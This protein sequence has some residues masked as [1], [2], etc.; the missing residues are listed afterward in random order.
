MPLDEDMRKLQFLV[1]QAKDKKAHQPESN[2]GTQKYVTDLL[3]QQL[4]Q[5]GFNTQMT[6]DHELEVSVSDNPISIGVNCNKPDAEG[7]FV[8]EISAHADEEQDWF[9]KIETQ[10]MIKQLAQ[11]VEQTLKD[12]DSFKSFEW[13]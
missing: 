5:H 1:D 8:C 11:A 3:S 7:R 9:Q 4:S 10:S 13:K 12:D 6:T 2:N